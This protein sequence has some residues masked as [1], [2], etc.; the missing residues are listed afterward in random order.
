MGVITMDILCEVG[1]DC[2]INMDDVMKD[3]E[4]GGI[5]EG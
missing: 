1:N 3:E 4:E 5:Y 2:G